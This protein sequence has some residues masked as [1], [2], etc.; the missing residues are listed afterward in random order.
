MQIGAATVESSRKL[1]E[2]IKNGIAYDPAI[3]HL[4]IYPKKP[5]TLIQNNICTPM[6]IAKLF[7]ITKIWKQTKYPPTDEWIKKLWYIYT[8]EN[9]SAMKKKE[10]LHFAKAWMDLE[11]IMLSE[12]SLSKKDM[13]HMISLIYE[14]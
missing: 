12:V 10:I 3:A 13:Y 6:F 2:K 9:Y 4:G 5:K 14:T 8:K 1:P 7:I 11:S